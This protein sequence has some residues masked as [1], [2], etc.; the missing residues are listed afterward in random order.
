MTDEEFRELLDR[1]GAS[2]NGWPPDTAQ[3]VRLLLERSKAAQAMLDEMVAIEE[4]LAGPGAEPP[5]DLADRI[6]AS[7]FHLNGSTRGPAS[8]P[9]TSDGRGEP[10]PARHRSGG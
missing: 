7:A 9:P 6:F 4:A 8:S 3:P 5:P 2:P 1:Y 10:F